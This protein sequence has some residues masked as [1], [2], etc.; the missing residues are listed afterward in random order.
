MLSAPPSAPKHEDPPADERCFVIV[1]GGGAGAIAAQ[2][3]REL[4]SPAASSCLIEKT[5][6][7][8]IARS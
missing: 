5:V 8:T 4:G 1:G 6:C 2:T 7:R 3:L